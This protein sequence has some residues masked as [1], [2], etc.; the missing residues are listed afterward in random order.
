MGGIVVGHGL[1]PL[2]LSV[3]EVLPHG[4]VGVD[5]HEAGG[6]IAALG[7]QIGLPL[8]LAHR[9]DGLS[10]A[11]IPLQE[12]LPDQNLRIFDEHL[13]FAPFHP[14]LSLNEQRASKSPSD[15]ARSSGK[16]GAYL[17]YVTGLPGSRSEI[18]RALTPPDVYLS[19]GRLAAAMD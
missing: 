3:G 1:E 9:L 12:G 4:P 8:Q 16:P 10:K 6:H 19:S 5:V 17:L 2:R 11:D 13:A 14:L 18:W 7:V 15:E